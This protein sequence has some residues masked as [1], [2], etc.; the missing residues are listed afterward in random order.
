MAKNR[1]YLG[2]YD[3]RKIIRKSGIK[4]Y[5]KWLDYCA[6]KN[7]PENI[8]SNPDKTYRNLGW[9]GWIDWLDSKNI[10]TR[11]GR[12]YSINEN[13]FK[14]WSHDMSYVLGLWFTD[15]CIWGNR[16]SITLRRKDHLLLKNIL[17]A[18][19]SHH[20]LYYAKSCCKIDISSKA[21][22]ESIINLGGTSR[23]SLTIK[24]PKIPKKYIS[25]FTRGLWDGDGS[26]YLNRKDNR[27][28][29]TFCSGSRRFICG[30]KRVIKENI[31]CIDLKI[32][33]RICKKGYKI[34]NSKLK[35]DS[36]L[37][38]LNLC[39]NDTIRLGRFLYGNC[40]CLR[41]ERK[42]KKFSMAGEIN[43]AHKDR[44]Y[45]GYRK[46]ECFVRQLKLKSRN[47]WNVYC[48]NV[49]MNE[50][51]P[52]APQ[53]IYKNWKGWQNF[54]G[55]KHRFISLFEAK[56]IVSKLNIKNR[57]IYYSRRKDYNL[58]FH[59]D[60]VYNNEGWRGWKDYFSILK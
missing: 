32:Y 51:I 59:P 28:R 9:K 55:Y 2:F 4:S 1:K 26:I 53:F 29:S 27:F 50:N 19:K 60:K 13:F 23:K 10:N 24:F 46:A 43:I 15:G 17:R 3:A 52:L 21:I 42:Y 49:G 36:I 18:M 25:D 22:V 16:F 37:Y 14:K 41:M 8:P 54:L 57:N 58:P 47:E 30:M 12:K 38:I 45:W 31:G 6:S 48:R 11:C 44:K 39:T 20:K 7:K 34:I 35:K 40:R 33:K 56:N 5:R